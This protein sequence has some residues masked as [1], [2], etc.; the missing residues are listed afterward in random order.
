MTAS[1]PLDGAG[2]TGRGSSPARQAHLREHNLSVVLREVVHRQVAPSR[3]DIAAGTGLTRTTVSALVDQ[4]AQAGLVQE[5]PVLRSKSAGRPA[6]PLAPAGGT[7]AAIGLEINVDYLGVRVLDLTGAVLAEKIVTADHRRSDPLAVLGDLT[8]LTRRTLVELPDALPIAGVCVA[9]PGLVDSVTGPLRLAPN[10]GWAE[11]DVCGLLAR[12]P[13][14]DGLPIEVA[15]EATLAA[16][17]EVSALRSEGIESF[18]Y[19]SGEIGIG[20]ALVQDHRLRPG[21]RGWGGEI[22]HTSVDPAG[23]SCR[24][25]ST[26]CLEQFAGKD[27]LTSAAGLHPQAPIGD[28]VRLARSGS[29][30][31]LE[32]L[33]NAG[34]A[35]GVALANMLNLLDVDTVVFGGL[36]APLHPWLEETLMQ[37][38]STRVLSAR[39]SPVTV[40]PALVSDVAALTG[41]ARNVLDRLI[42][43]PMSWVIRADATL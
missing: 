3:A 19:V 7:L 40:R 33:A 38:L 41:A 42:A 31:A 2:V 21:S 28:L 8:D 9:L 15:N 25:G 18:F 10:L 37:Q 34:T 6:V 23:P 12:H 24:C 4:L 36:Y 30:R 17:A 32:A 22:G 16:Q 27:A 26:G 43:D 20:G 39:W 11:V 1:D 13:L 14:F 5:L 29:P 35:L